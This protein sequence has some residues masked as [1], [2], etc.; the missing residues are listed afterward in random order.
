VMP[1]IL[2][3][4]HS[5]DRYVR[6]CCYQVC[7]RA[8][9]GDLIDFANKDVGDDRLLLGFNSDAE[10]ETI[11]SVA[12]K[13]IARCGVTGTPLAGFGVLAGVSADSAAVD[14]ANPRFYTCPIPFLASSVSP[15][16]PTFAARCTGSS[17]NFASSSRL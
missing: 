4:I 16:I 17:Q 5:P 2:Q 6:T 3:Q 10:I 9:W 1:Y 11:G 12:K 14:S 7:E 8:N 15:S 13:Y